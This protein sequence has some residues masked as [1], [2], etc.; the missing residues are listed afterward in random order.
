MDI[1]RLVY[2][3]H[4]PCRVR[5][6]LEDNHF[7][8][9][10]LYEASIQISGRAV[11]AIVIDLVIR[12]PYSELSNSIFL[13]YHSILSADRLNRS[14]SRSEMRPLPDYRIPF[15]LVNLGTSS[16]VASSS[17]STLSS[18]P[19]PR[20]PCSPNCLGRSL[21]T[22]S[23]R[24]AKVK[25]HYEAL[26]LQKNATKQQVKARFYEVSISSLIRSLLTNSCQRNITLMR[27]EGIKIDS[28]RSMMRIIH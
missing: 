9:V 1:S 6:H 28:W 21:H 22:T 5:N 10:H 25:S 26:S 18:A 20:P 7:T 17:R 14:F 23:P 4:D 24:L 8:Y 15:Q 3:V 2:S 12:L 11:E 19:R 16:A 27:L 13:A